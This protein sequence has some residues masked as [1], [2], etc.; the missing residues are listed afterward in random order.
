MVW[1]PVHSRL[2]ATSAPVGEPSNATNRSSWPLIRSAHSVTVA[3]L[4]SVRSPVSRGSPIIPVA[5]PASTIGRAPACWKRR[6]VS[7]GMRLPACR[8]GAV[9]SNPQ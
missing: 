3:T 2:F 1:P 7:S 4:F 5:P 8:L 6:S 9:G